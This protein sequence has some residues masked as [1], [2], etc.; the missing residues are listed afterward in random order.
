MDNLNMPIEEKI[1]VYVELNKKNQITKVFSDLFE[2]PAPTSIKIDEGFGD[3]FAHAQSQYFAKP[4]ADENGIYNYIYENGTVEEADKTQEQKKILERML[5]DKY[6]P[7]L[8]TSIKNFI[9]PNL[10][11]QTL[12]DDGEKISVSGLYDNWEKGQYEVGAMRNYSGQTWECHQAHDNAVYPDIT[13]DNP[14][15]WATF[16]RPLHAKSKETAR[17]WFKPQYGTT[18]MYHAG[19]YM[20]YTDEKTYKALRDTVYSPEEYAADWAMVEIL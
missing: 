12:K 3:K 10:S 5:N 15:V 4:I 13:P 1:G 20:V 11:V 19:E 7:D 17:P 8:L 16:W 2:Q 6:I 14:S 9:K 18:D